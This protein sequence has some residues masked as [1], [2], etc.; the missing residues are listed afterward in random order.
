[1]PRFHPLPAL[2]R[3]ITRGGK[4][5]AKLVPSE[6]PRKRTLGTDE[7]AF[8]VPDDFDDPLPDDLLEAFYS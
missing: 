5:V 8:V 3:C 4:P 2:D 7:G 1:L 6:A